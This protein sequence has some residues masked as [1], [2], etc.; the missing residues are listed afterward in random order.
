MGVRTSKSTEIVMG[1]FNWD[2][3]QDEARERLQRD[4]I[5][6]VREQRDL[7]EEHLQERKQTCRRVERT[8]KCYFFLA[9]RLLGDCT[10]GPITDEVGFSLPTT[11]DDLGEGAGHRIVF[12]MGGDK[13]VLEPRFPTPE[14]GS[15]V[16][17]REQ[18][19]E[20]GVELSIDATRGEAIEAVEQ[21]M[22]AW[23]AMQRR[24][25]EL[26]EQLEHRLAV[27]QNVLDCYSLGKP[28]P[29]E[30]DGNDATSSASSD[31]VGSPE[32]WEVNCA[33]M[34]AY[35]HE[36][37][38]PDRLR[39]DLDDAIEENTDIDSF[40]H[41]HAWRTLRENGY[42]PP[43]QGTDA[44]P[45]A[46]EEWAP[47]FQEKYGWAKARGAAAPLEWPLPRPR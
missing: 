45:K 16:V 28:M 40:G 41:E 10:D 29:W 9:M 44:L 4:G 31:F 24:V 20:T 22:R 36:H 34:Y 43:G 12:M 35:L 6:A 8:L 2:D 26:T 14:G 11:G 33:R 27:F 25:E 21:K 47:E 23:G 32:Q 46:L 15:H 38:M 18:F 1:D 17:K 13:P 19:Y 7:I 3:V 37:E 39:P 42:D 30:T 5:M